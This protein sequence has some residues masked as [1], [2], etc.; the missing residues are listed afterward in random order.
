MKKL[1]CYNCTSET[2]RKPGCHATCEKYNAWRDKLNQAKE[3]E[4]IEKDLRKDMYFAVSRM[5]GNKKKPNS[6]NRVRYSYSI[7]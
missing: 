1:A 6:I 2:G 5:Q 7:I 4:Q 3:K